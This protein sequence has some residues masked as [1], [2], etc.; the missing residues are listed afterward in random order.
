MTKTDDLHGARLI[1]RDVRNEVFTRCPAGHPQ[2]LR[3]HPLRGG[4]RVVPFPT[5]YWLVCPQ[6]VEAVSRLEHAGWIDRLQS[7]LQDDDA[8]AAAVSADHD[9]YI[10][11][12]WGQLDEAERERIRKS[13]LENEFK[14]RGIGGIRNRRSI[15]CLHLHFAHHLAARSTIGGEIERSGLVVP[16]PPQTDDAG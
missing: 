8:F 2:V 16:C 15:K 6:L 14:E 3:C 13:G 12:R 7:R 1:H 11:A 4:E 9:A 5:L 10:E